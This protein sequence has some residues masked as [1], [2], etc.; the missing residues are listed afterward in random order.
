MKEERLQKIIANS[1]FCSRRKAE[2]LLTQGRVTIN[3]R[4]AKV[5]DKANPHL[6]KISIDR[7]VVNLYSDCRVI[8]LNKPLGVIS[9][10][11]DTHGRETVLEMLPINLRKGLYPIGRL[12]LNSRGAIILTNHGELALKL[13]H[14][15]YSHKKTYLVWVKGKPSIHALTK[16]RKGIMLDN[17]ITMSSAVEILESSTTKTLLKIILSEGRNRQIRRI[18]DYLGHP[19]VD[20]FRT[21]IAGIRL[22]NLKEGQ[23]REVEKQ[24]WSSLLTSSGANS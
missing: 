17:K 15:R 3:G 9:S 16:W 5:G 8:L 22:K 4:L 11:N 6:D 18:A 2:D 7:S 12:D 21:E 20:L 24:E 23:W 10:C 14:P 1:G 13:T 19:V